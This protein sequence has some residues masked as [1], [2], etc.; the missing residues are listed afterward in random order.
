M[1]EIHIVLGKMPHTSRSR[2]NLSEEEKKKRRRE[3]KKLSMRRARAK[4]DTAALEERRRKDR[5]R[6][7]RKKQDGLIKTI[8]DYTPR[9]QRQIRKMWRE[10]AKVRREK[11]K[12]RKQTNKILLNTPPSSPSSSFS[13]VELGRAVSARN[14]RRLKAKNDYLSFRLQLL[15]KKLAKY[16][17]RILRLKRKKYQSDN[18]DKINVKQTIHDFLL[19]DENSRLTAGKKETITRRKIKQQIRF[20]NDSLLNLFKIFVSKTGLNISYETFRR[21]RPFW[22][23]SPKVASRN[24]C[25]CRTHTNNDF[26]VYALH[27]A[28]II[29]HSTATDVAKSLCCNNVLDVSCLERNCSQCIG[30][31]VNF[32]TINRLDTIIYQRWVTKNVNVVINGQERKLK[33]TYKETVKTTQ[34]L[35]LNTLKVNLPIFMQHLANI[36]NQYKAIRQIK[37]NL[38]SVDG[39]L[40][41]DFSENYSFKYGTAI[42]SAHFGG[43]K[44]QL[45]MHTCVYYSFQIPHNK[46][47]TTSICTVS[48][49]LRH[50]PVLICA[51]LKP[52]IEQI[53]LITPDLKN[54]HILSDGPST[55]YRNKTMFQMIAN[56]L[57]NITNA[58]TI[59]WHFTE[60]GH[61]K[62]APDG[63]GGCLKRICDKAVANGR[64]IVDI[65]SFVDCSKENCKGIVVIPIDDTNV[66]DIQNIADAITVRPFKGTF[67]LHQIAWS[68]LEPNI[69]H[70]RRL[71]CIECAANTKCSHFEIGQILVQHVESYGSPSNLPRR[72]IIASPIVSSPNTASAST[73]TRSRTPE[74]IGPSNDT[75][76]PEPL[77]SRRQPLTPRKK[78]NLEDVSDDSD[79]MTSPSARRPRKRSGL[80]I[81]S[82][83]S[84]TNS[85]P[86]KNCKRRLAI[87][88][89][90]DSE[91]SPPK[92]CKRPIG[93][94]YFSD[95]SIGKIF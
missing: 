24:T 9:Q 16:R 40:H 59:T 8:A 36:I 12:I 75:P 41:I 39:L 73:V 10:K 14:R 22:V 66:L 43:S 7:Q 1:H 61:G 33:K 93:K 84:D 55:Q 47:Q 69:L 70:A 13:R 50:D 82:D 80:F 74:S 25:L 60:T 88:I 63:V 72:V 54:L 48:Q 91:N 49:N 28:K 62:G 34:Q 83:D 42:Q 79:F 64:D 27:Q 37:Q 71:S 15:E 4:M 23:L 3:Q 31:Y 29:P 2:S 6:Y 46:I 76:S 32:N 11:E 19:E 52:V 65:D 44:E 21:H 18:S 95:D 94:N 89:D 56:Y 38:T 77:I 85:S 81:E 30:K 5:E 17:M 20:L 35:L 51:H 92:P 57:G 53:K 45:S 87:F 86:P 58:E 78:L 68:I 90:T 26:I 67:K